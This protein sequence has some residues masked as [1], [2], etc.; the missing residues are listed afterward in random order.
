[1][2]SNPDFF[3]SQTQIIT[4]AIIQEF[5]P[6]NPVYYEKLRERLEKIIEEEERRRIKD[7]SYFNKLKAVYNEAINADKERKKLGFS[8]QFEFA[9]YELLLQSLKNDERAS[10][11]IT[12]AIFAKVKE[13]AKIVGWKTKRSSEK[14]MNTAI[15]DILSENNSN[16]PEDKAI[17]LTTRI[18]DLARKD[19]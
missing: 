1:L 11:D 10:R 5:A 15:Y 4:I 6:T 13:E 9:V 12:N 14:K 2:S 19:L 7:A 3:L 8:T 18:I 17:E 16:F